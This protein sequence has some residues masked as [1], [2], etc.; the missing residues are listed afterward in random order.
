VLL[1][2]SSGE[3]KRVRALLAAGADG[4]LQKP[5]DSGAVSA[6]VGEGRSR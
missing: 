3:K 6:A 5:Y 4:F 2:G 1:T